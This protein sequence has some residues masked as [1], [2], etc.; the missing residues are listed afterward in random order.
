[1]AVFEYRGLVA[2][3]GKQVHGVRDADNAK[4]LRALLRREGVLLTAAQEETKA[5]RA[6]GRNIDLFAFARRVSV[7]DVAMMTRQLATLV[8]AG[9]PLVEAVAALTEQVDK[10]ELKRTLTQ[11]R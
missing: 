9:I 3:S 2:A 11:V 7:G 10:L 4:V 1:M 8:T 6:Q 5:R